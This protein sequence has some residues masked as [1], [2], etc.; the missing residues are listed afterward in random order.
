MALQKFASYTR[1][2]TLLFDAV[3]HYKQYLRDDQLYAGF[4]ELKDTRS[5][6]GR[7]LE[8]QHKAMEFPNIED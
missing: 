2:I 4:I 3:D 7:C 6:Y 5:F 1:E 8:L